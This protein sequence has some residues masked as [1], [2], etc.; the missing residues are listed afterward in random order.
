MVK[1]FKDY[2]GCEVCIQGICV[3]GSASAGTHTHTYVNI[4]SHS[5]WKTLFNCSRDKAPLTCELYE[6]L[7][8]SVV[9]FITC[10][11]RCE[12]FLPA[13]PG[14]SACSVWTVNAV[15]KL[16]EQSFTQ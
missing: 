15:I 14:I 9:G 8:K 12:C 5:M 1:M 13:A 4:Y 6:H 10:L 3:C 16:L 7:R 11:D 2:F